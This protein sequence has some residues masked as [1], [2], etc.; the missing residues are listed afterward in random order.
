MVHPVGVLLLL[1]LLHSIDASFS[2]KFETCCSKPTR[3]AGLIV[4]D[5]FLVWTGP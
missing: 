1:L 5:M 4:F 2:K 3:I